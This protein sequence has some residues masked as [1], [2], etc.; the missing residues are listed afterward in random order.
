MVAAFSIHHPRSNSSYSTGQSQ[1]EW[2]AQMIEGQANIRIGLGHGKPNKAVRNVVKGGEWTIQPVRPVQSATADAVVDDQH[3]VPLEFFTLV[4][5]AAIPIDLLD[6]QWNIHALDA[7]Q[8]NVQLLAC[9]S[10]SDLGT[11]ASACSPKRPAMMPS[12]RC[13]QTPGNYFPSDQ[14]VF[15]WQPIDR[16]LR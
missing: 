6:R 16:L 3:L 10:G 8:F 7:A 5:N 1:G 13:R 11:N 4:L 14:G 9:C 12:T 2:P 15:Q